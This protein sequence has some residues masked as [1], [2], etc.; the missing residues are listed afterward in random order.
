MSDDLDRAFSPANLGKLSLKNR[1]IKA[2]TYEG[3]TPDGIPGDLLLKNFGVTRHGRVI[4]YDYDELCLV[5]ECRFRELPAP[6]SME[7]EMQ[8]DVW[9]Y[10]AD[11]DV[12]PEQFINFLGLNAALKQLFLAAHSELLQA[13]FWR[14]L[15]ERIEGGDIVSIVPYRRPTVKA[16]PLDWPL[17]DV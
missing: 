3:K 5:T 8:S 10:V 4:F 14:G 1:I 12:F 7:E 11:N 6:A 13:Q 16:R 15:Q 9:F 2:A 17:L